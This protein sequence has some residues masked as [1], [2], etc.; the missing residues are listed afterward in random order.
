MSKKL[1]GV[2]QIPAKAKFILLP[3][4]TVGTSDK[5]VFAANSDKSL[6]YGAQLKREHIENDAIDATKIA[7]NAVN[8]EHIAMGSD[9]QGDIM[10]MGSGGATYQ[11]LPKP[12]NAYRQQ[13]MMKDDGTTLEYKAGPMELEFK[14]DY[15]S[16]GVPSR[17]SAYADAAA[18]TAAG[19]H[20]DADSS[21]D[22]KLDGRFA[23]KLSH[24]AVFGAD[25]PE[26]YMA[27]LFVKRSDGDFALAGTDM[28]RLVI[29]SGAHAGKYAHFD[30]NEVSSG[31]AV[32]NV[33]FKL[34]IVPAWREVDAP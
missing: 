33:T 4:A 32:T 9:A 16:A 28:R 5:L 3:T 19:L 14:L 21:I 34:V 1:L 12:T 18:F 22:E 27:Q 11:R 20:M 17:G 26:A 29:S 15:S 23:V 2:H 30:L 7:D 6:Y 31:S 24:S 10:V 25:A 13:L 8:G